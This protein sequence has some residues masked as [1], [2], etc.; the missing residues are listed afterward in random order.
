MVTVT[1]AIEAFSV[2]RMSARDVRFKTPAYKDWATKVAAL[3]EGQKGLLR[4]A[5]KHK[6][7]GGTFSVTIAIEYPEHIFTNAAGEISSKTIDV[8]NYEK[9]FVDLVFGDFMGVNDKH[10]TAMNSRKFSG[11][12]HAIHFSLELHA[13][14]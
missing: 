9:C 10:I 13:Q 11:S 7:T 8:T 14:A 6:A 2:N 4:L 3:L 12:R 1:L 5:A